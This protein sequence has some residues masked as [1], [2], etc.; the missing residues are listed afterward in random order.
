MIAF[1]WAVSPRD[2]RVTAAIETETDAG[3]LAAGVVGVSPPQPITNTRTADG[4]NLVNLAAGRRMMRQ[5]LSSRE[6]RHP[7]PVWSMRLLP[8]GVRRDG[9]AIFSLVTTSNGGSAAFESGRF[10]IDLRAGLAR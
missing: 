6:T 8:Y 10:R 3:T 7:L 9:V 1:T 5:L 4:A 2:A